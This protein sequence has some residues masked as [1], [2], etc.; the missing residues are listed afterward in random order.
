MYVT[1]RKT[2]ERRERADGDEI[3]VSEAED[4]VF[5]NAV[6]DFR[7]TRPGRREVVQCGLDPL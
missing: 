6:E 5:R 1:M 7:E 4:P 2:M 3:T